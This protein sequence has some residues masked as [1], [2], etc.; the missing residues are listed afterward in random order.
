V[1][2]SI[3]RALRH[4]RITTNGACRAIALLV[5]PLV[6]AACG[7]FRMPGSAASPTPK[8]VWHVAPVA[9]SS[10]CT[11]QP[12]ALVGGL[13]IMISNVDRSATPPPND[14][15]E[16]AGSHYLR[17]DVS[18]LAVTGTHTVYDP[19]AAM[20]IVIDE[21]G[22]DSM[23]NSAPGA[24][25]SYKMAN[26]DNFCGPAP[27]PSAIAGGGLGGNI[28]PPLA[29]LAPGQRVGPVH[30]CFWVKGAVN[31]RLTYAWWPSI[32]PDTPGTLYKPVMIPL[33]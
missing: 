28:A 11:P 1:P 23:T 2:A 15:P 27:T 29:T 22:P 6:L 8:L 32:V 5:L 25:I 13:Q 10:P 16:P 3:R 18:F 33:A 14:P 24:S 31:Q 4:I 30:M 17:L 19:H 7:S 20:P 26:P 21:D 12:C 9:V